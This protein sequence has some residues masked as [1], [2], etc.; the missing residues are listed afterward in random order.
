MA[1]SCPSET[2]RVWFLLLLACCLLAGCSDDPASAEPQFNST[3]QITVNPDGR[4]PSAILVS[5]TANKPVKAHYE[6]LSSDT[7]WEYTSPEF[8]SDHR[9]PLVGLAAGGSHTLSITLIDRVGRKKAA[10]VPLQVLL[11][12][13]SVEFGSFPQIDGQYAKSFSGITLLSAFRYRDMRS[14]EGV[15]FTLRDATYGLLLALDSSLRVRWSH[16]VDYLVEHI[17]QTSPDTLTLVSSR[18]RETIDFMGNRIQRWRGERQGPADFADLSVTTLTADNL[19]SRGVLLANGHHLLLTTELRVLE[20]YQKTADHAVDPTL[21]RIYRTLPTVAKSVSASDEAAVIGDVVIEVTPAG[22]IVKRWNLFDLLDYRRASYYGNLSMWPRIYPADNEYGSAPSWT[23]ANGIVYDASTDTIIVSVPHQA[24][25]VGIGRES[26]DLKWILGDPSG[27]REQWADKLLGRVAND[28]GESFEWPY[29][30]ASMALTANDEL[31]V[32][33]NGGYGAVPPNAPKDPAIGR[34]R[35][36]TLRIDE[37]AMQV[38]QTFSYAM[39]LRADSQESARWTGKD[40]GTVAVIPDSTDKLVTQMY[41]GML[42]RVPANG[43][44][45]ESI[46]TIRLQENSAFQWGI[47]DA[48]IA[49]TIEPPSNY[50]FAADVATT[51]ASESGLD[52]DPTVT[53]LTADPSLPDLVIDGQWS[54]KIGDNPADAEQGLTLVQSGKLIEGVIEGFPIVAWVQGNTFSMTVRR[55]GSLG[56]VRLRYRGVI[57]TEQNEIQGRVTIDHRGAPA[58]SYDW[59]ALKR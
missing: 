42:F 30:P 36:L 25:I 57:N 7:E 1:I 59:T 16:E 18:G 50:Q 32:F 8:Q 15:P 44:N 46:A 9:Q 45:K 10:E 28:H 47:S 12:E 17:E 3:P 52:R 6:L 40:R 35:V 58:G 2:R 26:G 27:W 41:S 4:S 20:G 55:E 23:Q 37:T 13:A 5:F 31:L 43:G 24:A 14:T 39:A 51:L 48:L 38:E 22:E 11:P 54:L 49:P 21:A 56:Q 29:F 19:H 33:D 53:K 34:T